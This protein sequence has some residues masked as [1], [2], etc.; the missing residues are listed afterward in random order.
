MKTNVL[1]LLPVMF[2]QM[3][4]LSLSSPHSP[5]S[6]PRN[7]LW[8]PHPH[9]PLPSNQ[10]TIP[11]AFGVLLRSS[12][13]G[14]AGVAG[15]QWW[16]NTPGGAEIVPGKSKDAPLPPS[17]RSG[18]PPGQPWRSTHPGW[19]AVLVLVAGG[20]ALPAEWPAGSP[21]E[22]Q[23]RPAPF[24]GDHNCWGLDEI[25]TALLGDPRGCCGDGQEALSP[26]RE[27]LLRWA[28]APVWSDSPALF[29]RSCS[30]LLLYCQRL[31][32]E[33]RS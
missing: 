11:F 8:L 14:A 23:R 1:Q 4:V 2:P 18:I 33:P 7:S 28:L 30:G 22:P 21:S 16:Q 3:W 27:W 20:A 6:L 19:Q 15:P 5:G 13:T 29:L 17:L 25:K 24:S 32:R 10:T 26:A 31:L 12:C 9:P